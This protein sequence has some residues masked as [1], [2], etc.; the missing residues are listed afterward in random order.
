MIELI[1]RGFMDILNSI[2]EASSL[3]HEH[4]LTGVILLVSLVFLFAL[5]PRARIIEVLLLIL[6]IVAITITVFGICIGMYIKRVNIK[7]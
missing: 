3:A 5:L 1:K 7:R 2:D 4:S 6:G